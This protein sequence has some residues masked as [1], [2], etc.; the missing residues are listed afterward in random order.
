M[1]SRKLPGFPLPEDQDVI[2]FHFFKNLTY[3]TRML[4]Y[5]VCITAGFL[6]QIITVSAWPGAFLLILASLLIMIKGLSAKPS[7]EVRKSSWTRT[8]MDKIRQINQIKQSI[9]KWDKDAL[10]ISNKLGCATFILVFA[11]ISLICVGVAV[12]VSGRVAGIFIIDSIILI[13]PIW[14]NGMRIKGHQELLYIKTDIIVEL[15]EY[16]EMLKK[17][18][19]NFIPSMVLAKDNEGKEFPTD[20]RF[21][22]VFDNA[23]AHFYGI[24]AQININSVNSTNYPYFYCVITAKKGFGLERYVKKLAIPKG[25]ITEFSK[26]ADAEVIVIRQ[27][28]TKTSGYHTEMNM[29]KTI[30]GFSLDLARIIIEENK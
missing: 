24:Q 28:T 26:D 17:P 16:F 2:K 14:F 21:N 23:P 19:E 10:D 6:L 15:E 30:L 5:S 29:Q 7:I 9:N 1:K 20:C 8:S 18:G 4:M 27:R 3:T 13:A 11:V 22:I 12:R 25:I